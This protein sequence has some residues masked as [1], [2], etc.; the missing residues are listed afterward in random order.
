MVKKII[1]IAL[2]MVIGSSCR[3]LA[4]GYRIPEQSL[5]ATALSS[6]YIA[7]AN[8]PDAAYYNP[9]NMSW[10]REGWDTELDVSLIYLPSIKYKNT[11]GSPN[12][13]IGG[14]DGSTKEE[15]FALPT[16]FTVS[17]AFHNFRFGFAIV[18]PAGLA[19]RW[20]DPYQKGFA[21]ESSLTVIEA[22][23]TLSYKLNEMFSIGVGAR[24]L[25]SMATLKSDSGYYIRDMDGDATEYGYN[26]A[27]T[28]KPVKELSL[29]ATYRSEIELDMEGDVTLIDNVTSFPTPIEYRG[30]G[31]VT[32][33]I[34]AVL[35]L[36]AAY[37]LDKA[38]FEF[39]Y[40]RSYWSIY[41]KLDFNYPSPLPSTALTTYFDNP[42][43]KDW[44][45]VDAYK[46]GLTYLWS[47]KLT[48]MAGGGIYGNPVP[49]AT[50][51]FDLPD[52]DAW[53]ASLGFRYK[54]SEKLSYG[55]AYLHAE[56]EDRTATSADI[57][58]DGT[59]SGAS[60]NLLAFSLT[61]LF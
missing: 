7:N 6:A 25:Y 54:H 37:T 39:T 21:Q 10:A 46:F 61:Y 44:N 43:T 24:L 20:D 19:K 60:S 57:S 2:V 9:A 1:Q 13:A 5:N 48:L 4:A 11:P 17:P 29:A 18:S 38:T 50:I 34:P 15:Y 56:K 33:P 45:D 12:E 47:P 8:G 59:F 26:V 40:E 36:A 51:S 27:L 31:S 42:I 14:S 30:N 35:S 52:S 58:V 22:N 23:P 49:D 55:A 41:D 3:V 32:I 28:F 53:F 16:F